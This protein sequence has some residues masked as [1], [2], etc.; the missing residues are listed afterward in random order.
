LL[1][2]RVQWAN[3][4]RKTQLALQG[5]ATGVVAGSRRRSLLVFLNLLECQAEVIS[6]FGL[7]DI[8]LEPSRSATDMLVDRI[9]LA[10][11]HWR[12]SVEIAEGSP[13]GA[14]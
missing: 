5:F 6:D 7:A 1:F 8:E 4:R 10:F 2:L 12:A 9:Y 13:I 14:A 11:P 3:P